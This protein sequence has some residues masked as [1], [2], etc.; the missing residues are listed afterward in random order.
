MKNFDKMKIFETTSKGGNDV[1]NSPRAAQADKCTSRCFL[2]LQKD[3]YDS[4]FETQAL[5][6]ILEYLGASNKGFAA[7]KS[8]EGYTENHKT[9]EFQQQNI[10]NST[11]IVLCASCNAITTKLVSLIRNLEV[12]QLWINYQVQQVHQVLQASQNEYKEG[13]ENLYVPAL[14]RSLESK[15]MKIIGITYSRKVI[16]CL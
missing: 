12:T 6:Y 13:M 10:E 9:S 16:Y 1:S 5:Q 4:K 8:E 11:L 3:L 15:C 14:R 2:C 7:I